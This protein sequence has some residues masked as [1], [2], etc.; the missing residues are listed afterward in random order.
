MSGNA[1]RQ[2]K[3]NSDDSKE[4]SEIAAAILVFAHYLGIDLESPQ[5]RHLISIAEEAF[6]NIP[7]GWE[8][9]IGEY[10]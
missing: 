2:N 8:L 4:K 10:C 3:T 5:Q 9:G 6:Q 1:G 7:D